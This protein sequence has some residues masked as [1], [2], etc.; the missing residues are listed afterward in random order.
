MDIQMKDIQMQWR[1]AERVSQSGQTND[2][3]DQKQQASITIL[4]S[5]DLTWENGSM[6]DFKYDCVMSKLL[7]KAKCV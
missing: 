1:G 2:V 5:T 4:R 7:L 6:N 3:I